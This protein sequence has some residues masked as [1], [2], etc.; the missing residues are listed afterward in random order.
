MNSDSGSGSQGSLFHQFIKSEIWKS[1]KKDLMVKHIIFKVMTDEVRSVSSVQMFAQFDFLASNL[2]F[3]VLKRTS[4]NQNKCTNHVCSKLFVICLKMWLWR[5]LTYS[6]PIFHFLRKKDIIL[7]LLFGEKYFQSRST[8]ILW[9]AKPRKPK[10]L[11]R[12]V[13]STTN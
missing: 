7:I 3:F 13:C 6:I 9:K 12:K 5:S 11:R 2:I 4:K 1:W 10:V 8:H